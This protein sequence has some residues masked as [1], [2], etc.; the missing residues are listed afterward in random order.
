MKSTAKLTLDS[1]LPEGIKT[2]E[3][4]KDAI[5]YRISN[6]PPI[7]REQYINMTYHIADLISM[8]DKCREVYF[9]YK[10]ADLDNLAEWLKESAALYKMH[11]LHNRI[12]AAYSVLMERSVLI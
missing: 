8:R 5:A 4:M 10:G 6:L 1:N 11:L 9:F 2:Y 3:D 7:S 12:N